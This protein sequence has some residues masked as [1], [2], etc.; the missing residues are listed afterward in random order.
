MIRQRLSAVILVLCVAI[1]ACAGPGNPSDG[2][3]NMPNQDKSV[4]PDEKSDFEPDRAALVRALQLRAIFGFQISFDKQR[5]RWIARFLRH[6]CSVLVEQVE[7]G[8]KVVSVGTRDGIT[9]EELGLDSLKNVTAGEFTDKLNEP[10][11]FGDGMPRPRKSQFG[12]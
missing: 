6:G 4:T 8:Y 12:C 5:E 3:Y 11:D 10:L 9:P 7:G 2:H 1:T